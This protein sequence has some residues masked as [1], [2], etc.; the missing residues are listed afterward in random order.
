[1]NLSSSFREAR[2]E[3][4]R[5]GFSVSSSSPVESSFLWARVI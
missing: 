2:V 4:S 1:M 5:M 3:G